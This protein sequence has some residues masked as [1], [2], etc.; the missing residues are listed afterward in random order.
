MKEWR[1]YAGKV[2]FE[3]YAA[4]LHVS[5]LTVRIMCNR[6]LRK[7][8]EMEDYLYPDEKKLNHPLMMK[9]MEQAVDILIDKIR[10]GRRIRIV[11][12]YDID[13]VCAV[14]IL[15]RGLKGAGAD[16]D[17]YI[18]HRMKDGYGLNRG[19]VEKALQDGVDTILT[20]DNGIS[21]REEVAYGKEQGMTVIVTD[22]HDIPS[23]GI[24]LADAVVNPKQE[25]CTYPF[26]GLCGAA[27][28]WKLVWALFEKQGLPRSQVWDMLEFAAIATV[29]D[30]VELQGENRLMVKLGIQKLRGTSIP[31]LTALIE[32]CDLKPDAIGS[33]HIGFVLGPAINASGRLE[34]ARLSEELLLCEELDDETR[35]KARYLRAL[36]DSRKT[37]TSES[38]NEALCLVEGSAMA[39]DRVLVIYL[40]HCSESIAGIVAGRL[41]EHYYRPCIILT[42]SEADP[43]MVKGSGRS[44]P[45]YDLFHELEKAADLMTRFGGHPL[46]AGLSLKKEHVE[47][48]RRKLN[49]NCTLTEKELTERLWIDIPLPIDRI[50]PEFI[51]EM[52]LLEPFGKGNEKPV[53]ADR[54]IKIL[55]GYILGKEKN[56]LK[57]LVESPGGCRMEALLFQDKDDFLA[58]FESYYGRD[59]LEQ[60]FAGFQE[61][62]N[63][64]C[65]SLVYYPSVNIYRGVETVQI[66]LQDFHFH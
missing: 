9:D 50:T 66:V 45:G 11:G 1:V 58:L 54:N 13:G 36:N 2:D 5:P 10:A 8:E 63:P 3:G 62:N 40:P 49:E 47:A 32:A 52:E 46:A 6:G 33:Y 61:E 23:A 34:S 43:D 35:E 26:K 38:V 29:G 4:R 39:Q 14:A 56:V 28:A 30:V 57:L 17:W 44:I 65:L 22:H 59:A 64:T 18:P 12:D 48:F 51:R 42:D 41:R 15:Y 21:A 37:M 19:I 24:P 55:R 53:F 20:C 25:D 60:L 31:G 16:V 7:L 27:V